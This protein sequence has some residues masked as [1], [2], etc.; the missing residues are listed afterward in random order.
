MCLALVGTSV[1]C[2][3]SDETTDSPATT[4]GAPQ[5][6][7]RLIVGVPQR[8]PETIL[9]LTLESLTVFAEDGSVVPYLAESVEP[10]ESFDRWTIR[11]RPDI[12][13]HNGTPL[14][15]EAVKVNLDTYA[16]SE[17]YA[18]DPFA[19][20]VSTTVVDDMTVE[21]ELSRPWAS[22][23]AYLTAEQS[24]GTGLIAAPETLEAMGPLFL[25]DPDAEGLYGTGP[26]II[27]E[28][29][30]A[31]EVW[32][33][34]KNPDY[35]QEGLPYVNEVEVRA[36]PDPLSRLTGVESGDLDVAVLSDLPDDV[37][38]EQVVEQEGDVQVLAVALNMGVPPLDDPRVR[39][40]LTAATDVDA[41]AEAAD[42]DP[43]MIATGPFGPDSS[44]GDP[45]APRPAHDPERARQLI[46]EVEAEK[47]PVTFRLAT[48]DLQIS[49][50]AV[51]QQL[52]DQWAEVG[53]EVELDVIDPFTQTATLLVTADFDAVLGRIFGMPD[54]DMYYFWWHSSALKSE[55]K[56][57]A[58]NYVGLDDP[59]LDEALDEARAT[60][61]V[62]ERK[63]PMM[64]VSERLAA[65][66]PYVWLWGTRWYAL[67]RERVH[68]LDAAPVPDGGVRLAMIGP[69]VNLEA[70]WL[71]Q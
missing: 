58:Y 14:D 9:R 25:A 34:E 32:F 6:G 60:P 27:T 4:A 23:P 28:S 16:V 5:P 3:S 65:N 64:V 10:N 35:W 56:G 47:G 26:F 43:S 66:T 2:G 52:A 41:L 36:V 53:I 21:V 39:E 17:V 61:E 33:A 63:P 8:E 31:R 46:E 13:F 49:N 44:W 24:E 12:T 59:A 22:F 69:R 70:V 68:G 29:D 37:D 67:S 38:E 42:V 62:A 50:L 1:G 48:A 45:S 55:G 30:A 71:E 40:A 11:V 19:P 51:Q 18:T 57:A 7:G 15:A 20:I 54:P